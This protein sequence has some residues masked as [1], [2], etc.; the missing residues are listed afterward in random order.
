[1]EMCDVFIIGGGPAGSIAAAKLARAGYQVELVEK[2]KFPRFVIGESLLPRCNELLEDAGMLEAVEGAGFQFKGGVAFENE[3]NDIKIVH[4]EQ[5]MGQKHN[6]S[7]QVRR[8]AFDKLLLDEAQGMGAHITM[9]S[10]V[11][12]YDEVENIV[13]VLDKDGNEEKYQAKK[14]IDASGYGRVL[15]RLLDLDS[16]SALTLRDAIFCRVEND[17]RPTDG[18]DG[19]IYVY[20]VGDN[21]AW[22]WNIPLSPTVTS[23]GIVCSDEYYNSFDMSQEEFWDHI[24]TTNFHAKK[25]YANAQKINEVGFIGGYSSNVTKM[26]G[27]NF[28]MVGNATEFLDPVF[29]S[30][31][32]LALESGAKAADLI[33]RELKGEKVDWQ[34]DYQDYMMIGV[35]V[36]REYVEAWYDGRLQKIL[37]SKAATDEKIDR[38]IVS[39]L[40]GYVWDRNNM[41]VHSPTEAVNATYR[42]MTKI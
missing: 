5:N 41:F 40:S 20:I 33:I 28:V 4:F 36:F 19:Y 15:P 17:M 32:T 35:D 9:E 12:A 7:F 26:F 6:S 11:I 13:T 34:I 18:T 27:K 3:Q 1:M 39:V 22:I 29:S 2:V 37:F 21:D 30:G 42:A 8:E 16:S 25:R 31:V 38:K 14:V 24:T 23:V 10:E